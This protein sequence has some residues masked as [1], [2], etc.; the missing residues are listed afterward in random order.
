MSRLKLALAD[1]S[2]VVGS[3]GAAEGYY[4][5][6][7]QW[8]PD[9]ENVWTSTIPLARDIVGDGLDPVRVN[10]DLR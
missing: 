7:D 6:P 3:A 9:W 1:V 8:D 5:L 4:L 2:Q 10:G